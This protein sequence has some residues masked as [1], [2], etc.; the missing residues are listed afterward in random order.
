MSLIIASV[1]ASSAASATRGIFA[2]M[3]RTAPIPPSTTPVAC[4]EA[5]RTID[6]FGK[7]AGSGAPSRMPNASSPRLFR[8]VR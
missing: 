8:Y 5:S 4:P 3:A 1:L 6:P 2:A 7:S